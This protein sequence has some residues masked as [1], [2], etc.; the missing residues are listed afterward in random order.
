MRRVLLLTC[1]NILWLFMLTLQ[2]VPKFDTSAP[3]SEALA[4]ANKPKNRYPAI[5]P[6][7][8]H[9]FCIHYSFCGWNCVNFTGQHD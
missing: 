7:K 8:Q 3:M 9:V 4:K 2:S 6:C 5:V 1:Q